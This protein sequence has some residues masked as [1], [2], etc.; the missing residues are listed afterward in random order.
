MCQ[1]PTRQA[2]SAVGYGDGVALGVGVGVG[3]ALAES[4]GVGLVAGFSS[5]AHALRP[6]ASATAVTTARGESRRITP[7]A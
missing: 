1:S 4:V 6:M 3:V 7:S 5:G 2:R